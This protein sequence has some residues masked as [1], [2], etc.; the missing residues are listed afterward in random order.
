MKVT[1]KIAKGLLDDVQADLLRSHAFAHERVGFISAGLSSVGRDLIAV[2]RAYRPVLD[3]DYLPDTSVGAMMG[4]EA[5]RKALE[6]SLQA[7][8][9]MFHVHTHGGW[10]I[11]GF[12]SVDLRE[13]QKFVPDFFKVSP[14]FPHG[15]IVLSDTSACGQIWLGRK[16][17]P[18]AIDEFAVV[19]PGLRKW[20]RR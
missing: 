20:G 14:R 13:N 2:A 17:A 15:A 3:E 10:G 6:W 19:G 9:A 16:H 11:P 8:H 5:I 18:A 7:G 1:F 12:S 4:R